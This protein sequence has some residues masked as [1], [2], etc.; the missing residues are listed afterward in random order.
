MKT[1][2]ILAVLLSVTAA[3]SAQSPAEKPVN[4]NYA[5]ASTPRFMTGKADAVDFTYEPSYKNVKP[6]LPY[7]DVSKAYYKVGNHSGSTIKCSSG[8]TIKIPADA[9]VDE[10]GNPALKHY[11]I[12]FN[13]ALGS[14]TSEGKRPMTTREYMFDYGE[15]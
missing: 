3:A 14:V 6:P 4:E 11:L 2:T 10:N 8:T 12:D 5:C 9:F 13:T 1:A 7:E 15:G